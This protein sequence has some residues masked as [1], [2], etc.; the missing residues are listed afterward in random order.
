MGEDK[1]S[2]LNYVNVSGFPLQLAIEHEV[3]K[4][5]L[6]LGWSVVGG[7]HHWQDDQTGKEGFI[8][9]VLGHITYKYRAVIECKRQLDKSWIFLSPSN[10]KKKNSAVLLWSKRM[11]FESPQGLGSFRAWDRVRIRPSSFIS[12]FCTMQGQSPN[13]RP[14]LE[15]VAS[16]VLLMAESLATEESPAVSARIG[17]FPMIYIPIIVTTAKLLVCEFEETDV[18]IQTGTIPFDKVEFTEVP[19]IQFEKSLQSNIESSGASLMNLLGETPGLAE[20]HQFKQRSVFVV[21]SSEIVNFL[22]CFKLQEE[23]AYTD[24]HYPW[25]TAASIV[26]RN[27]G[28]NL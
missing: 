1:G 14:L 3:T 25:T 8:D 12:A 13:D 10:S 9:I 19:Y 16:D 27:P 11:N 5:Q 28:A 4:A 6:E 15:R 21:H 22:S 2:Y 7:E 23:D 24:Y 18:E 26:N 20:L 17:G